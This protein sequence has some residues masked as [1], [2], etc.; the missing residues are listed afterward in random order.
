MR[1]TQ[2]V[3]FRSSTR[4]PIIS[5]ISLADVFKKIETNIQTF[6]EITGTST[7]PPRNTHGRGMRQKTQENISGV[8]KEPD[9]LL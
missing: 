6:S 7:R 3:I 4:A 2:L 8:L 9:F 5:L 1:L